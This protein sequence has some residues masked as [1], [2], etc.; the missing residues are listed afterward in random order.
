MFSAIKNKLSSGGGGANAANASAGRGGAGKS[1]N[2][3]I[4]APADPPDANIHHLSSVL[5]KKFSRGVHYNMKLLLR[6][7]RATGKTAMFNRLQVT[8]PDTE[9]STIQLS[10]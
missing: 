6:G 8:T 9:G 3:A 5:Q 1:A 10:Q 2:G 4:G 7:D